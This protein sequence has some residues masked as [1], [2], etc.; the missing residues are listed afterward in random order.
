MNNTVFRWIVFCTWRIPQSI[1]KENV[2]DWVIMCNVL[3][4]ENK[5][6]LIIK[7]KKKSNWPS[8]NIQYSDI[9]QK[10]KLDLKIIYMLLVWLC[11]SQLFFLRT[12]CI[13]HLLVDLLGGLLFFLR[14]EK[15]G[16]VKITINVCL[17]IANVL[18]LHVSCTVLAP[19][20]YMKDRKKWKI[21]KRSCNEDLHTC[22]YTTCT[23]GTHLIQ[24]TPMIAEL[25]GDDNDTDSITTK[26]IGADTCNNMTF[27][28]DTVNIMII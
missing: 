18:F 10:K 2:C 11:C 1:V 17:V 21:V 3:S 24:I 4:I 22:M 27:H 23:S 28:N 5:K 7:R 9:G 16:Y 12:C 13:V 15:K 20:F 8:V 25:N 14:H 19:S 26:A 6:Q